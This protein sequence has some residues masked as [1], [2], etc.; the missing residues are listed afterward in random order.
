MAIRDIIN[1]ISFKQISAELETFHPAL[2]SLVAVTQSWKHVMLEVYVTLRC[3]DPSLVGHVG[4]SRHIWP[5]L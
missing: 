5:L 3:F 1:E 4:P 2:V